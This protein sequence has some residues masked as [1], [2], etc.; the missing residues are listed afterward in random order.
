MISIRNLRSP[1]LT[2]DNWHIQ[3]DE[4]WCVLSKVGAGEQ[5]LLALFE[6]KSIDAVYS[7]Y[8]DELRL[9]D[10]NEL[11]V[12]SFR[13]LQHLYEEELKRDQSDYINAHDIGTR[14]KDFIPITTH[15]MALLTLIGL[16][17][18]IDTGFRQLSTGESRKLLILKAI[19]EGATTLVC[20]NPYDSLDAAARIRLTALF[21]QLHQQGVQIIY[22]INNRD[23][24][25]S[26][27]NRFATIEQG[28]VSIIEATTASPQR[29]QIDEYFAKPKTT[30]D[31]PANHQP[32]NCYTH[33][34]LAELKGCTVSYGDKAVLSNFNLSI[35][36]LEHT[37][38][39]GKNGSGKSTALQLIS[40]DCPQCFA[41]DVTVFGYRRGTGET[42]W[43]IKKH[44]GIVSA[45]LHR[46]YRVRCNVLT[47]VI[48]G[49]FDSIGV[50]QTV[51]QQHIDT[52]QQW[53]EAVGLAHHS[54]SLFHDLSHGEQRLALIAR[55]LVKS[56]LLL[57]LDEPTQ[58]LDEN[59][60][61]LLLSFLERLAADQQTTILY[62]SHREDEHL[63]L[64]TQRITI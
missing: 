17:H 61:T 54:K 39:Q 24:I 53:L 55:A 22:V 9:P 6:Q 62:V 3:P 13:S 5:H 42:I 21:T 56:P 4:H 2:I 52:A 29:T 45:D 1:T 41:N 36:P 20:E 14:V 49:F 26:H 7:P 47:V 32:L 51:T 25:P 60:R 11:A 35:K 46:S 34:L 38:V 44:L 37:L 31:W 10:H 33:T 63:P 23:D 58:G 15:S 43:D 64:F 59:H 28:K 50:Y 40:G 48:S 18:K 57:M 19:T 27:C 30:L 8:A 12:L 16:D